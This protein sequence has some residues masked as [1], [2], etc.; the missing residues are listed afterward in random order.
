MNEGYNRNA[1][2]EANMNS[3]V[4]QIFLLSPDRWTL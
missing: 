1:L 4:T 3:D 2:N